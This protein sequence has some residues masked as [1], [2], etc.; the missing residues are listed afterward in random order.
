M[1]WDQATP[2]FGGGSGGWYPS[3]AM[4]PVNHEPAIAFYVCSK[5]S[6]QAEGTC[7]ENEDELRIIQRV[8]SNWR[9]TLVDSEGGILPK[10]GF[11]ANGKR[12]VAY[13]VPKTKRMRLAVER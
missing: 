11:F 10:I 9:E 13:R 4:D 6:G 5:I 1:A 8:F 2:V 12:V 7:L 3:L